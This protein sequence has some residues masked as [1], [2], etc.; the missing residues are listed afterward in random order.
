[1]NLK[2]FCVGAVRKVIKLQK[3]KPYSGRTSV[4]HVGAGFC[5]K[6]GL[7]VSHLGRLI[8]DTCRDFSHW[9]CGDCNKVF[10]VLF[11]KT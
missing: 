8:E 1:M 7:A 10:I 11:R 6:E 3:P 5:Q 9:V 2:V 4:W